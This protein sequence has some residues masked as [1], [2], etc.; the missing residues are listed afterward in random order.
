MP[1]KRLDLH[2]V[3]PFDIDYDRDSSGRGKF[4]KAKH[5]NAFWQHKRAAAIHAKSGCYVFATRAA[6]GFKP[7]YAGKTDGPMKGECF[8]QLNTYNDVLFSNKKG[9]PVMFFVVP[10]GNKNKMPKKSVDDLET[11]LIQAGYLRNPDIRNA[12][13]KKPPLWGIQGILRS[14]RGRPTKATDKFSTMMRLA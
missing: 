7:W 13:K 12:R 8:K 3:G 11:Y 4:I 14:P 2:V 10:Q 6:K 9:R 5:V 1:Q